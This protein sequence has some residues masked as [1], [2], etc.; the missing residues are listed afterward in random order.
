M[1]TLGKTV[2]AVAICLV[3]IAVLFFSRD[4]GAPF[5]YRGDG[6]G[7]QQEALESG[8]GASYTI[9]ETIGTVQFDDGAIFLCKTKDDHLVLSYMF[10]NKQKT[11]Y[12]L[13][14]YYVISDPAQSSWYS[15]EN[16][17]KTNYRLTLADEIITVCDNRAVEF[18]EYTVNL[19]NEEIKVRLYY[20]RVK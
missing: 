6:Y 19:N 5:G 16:K 12:Y 20:N 10:L 2:V 4:F 9:E 3:I 8:I 18:E 14:S 17:V 1:N 7:T 13:E 11:K 15:S